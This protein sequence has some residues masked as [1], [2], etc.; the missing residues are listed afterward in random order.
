MSLSSQQISTLYQQA[1]EIELHAFKAGN[2][3]VYADGHD[4]NVA[5]FQL[6][7]KA[8]AIALSNPKYS[9]GEKIYYAIQA[10]HTA[11][12]CNTNLGI[13]LLC[14][15]LI[16]ALESPAYNGDLRAS[17][18]KVLNNTTIVD[19]NW[20]FQAIALANP[21]GLGKSA[22]ADVH[23]TASMTLT[24]S[25]QIAANRDRI[26][27]QYTNYYK[28]IFE[29]TII[30]YNE[31]MNSYD[32]LN[33]SAVAVYA[34]LLS[35]YSDSHIERKYGNQYNQIVQEQMLLMHNELLDTDTPQRLEPMLHK[36]D[37][38][39]KAAG[40]NPGTSADLT[41][42]TIFVYLINSLP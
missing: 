19:A 31:G 17:L 10:T 33:W 27:L 4:M 7:A 2:V 29:F 23:T 37:T 3:S 32:N 18:R 6:S 38:L 41:V 12:G 20:V 8:S 39:F 1:C 16:V 11:V 25:M 30:R 14:A 26:A 9:L 5:D 34:A 24:E 36:I 13:V 15:P 22:Q 21:G 40:I 28:D 42:A 35:R